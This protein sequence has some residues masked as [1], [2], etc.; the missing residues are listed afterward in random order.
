[1]EVLEVETKELVPMIEESKLDSNIIK[2]YIDKIK[3]VDALILG[4]THYPSLKEEFLKYL[5][6]NI[7]I[8]DMGVCLRDKLNIDNKG[9]Y[10]LTM[11]FT[12]ID[13][14]LIKNIDK[15]IHDNYK[16]IEMEEI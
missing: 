12:K 11:Y 15:I 13:N 14:V 6:N 4:C 7:K 9:K 8:I 16:I 10:N 2:S 3:D 1:M 5:N